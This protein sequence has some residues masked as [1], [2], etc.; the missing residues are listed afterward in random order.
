MKLKFKGCENEHLIVS[1]PH[2]L[3]YEREEDEPQSRWYFFVKD[4][5]GNAAIT[6]SRDDAIL[7]AK[8][9]LDLALEAE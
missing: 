7:L 4:R 6:L 1:V 8:N 5:K 2:T 3:V 9:I